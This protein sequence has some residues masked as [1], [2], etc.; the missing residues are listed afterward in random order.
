MAIRRHRDQLAC[1]RKPGPRRQRNH[2]SILWF[3]PG[4]Y[5]STSTIK[6]F[7]SILLGR[8]IRS[9]GYAQL[10]HHRALRFTLGPE[11][12]HT[13]LITT[14]DAMRSRRTLDIP[15]VRQNDTKYQ[16]AEYTVSIARTIGKD[17][18]SGRKFDLGH[19][20]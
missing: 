1:I 20:N 6:F 16:V 13:R 18:C 4:W 5:S 15:M 2:W 7:T 3:R 12:S 10:A 19:H 8:L 11:I 17:H 14:M 9:Q